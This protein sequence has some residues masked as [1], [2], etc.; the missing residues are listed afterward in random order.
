MYVRFK[1][2]RIA[3]ISTKSLICDS[4]I[5]AA[6]YEALNMFDFFSYDPS[7]SVEEINANA[8]D[9]IKNFI[10]QSD[11]IPEPAKELARNMDLSKVNFSQMAKE[12]TEK[13]KRLLL[14]QSYANTSRIE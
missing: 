12:Q 8:I 9:Q 4:A 7:R 11:I 10:L 3:K 13:L 6:I 1:K 2:F 14:N 5:G